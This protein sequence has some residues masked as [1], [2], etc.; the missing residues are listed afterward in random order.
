MEAA[1]K[2]GWREVRQWLAGDVR[3]R[4]WLAGEEDERREGWKEMR[5]WLPGGV[6][7]RWWPAGNERR[8]G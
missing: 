4:C 8:G 5:P 6:R 2:E 1:G 7:M 3:W